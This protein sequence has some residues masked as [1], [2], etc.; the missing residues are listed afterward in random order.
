MHA[1]D[2]N[3]VEHRLPIK[4]CY[5]PVKQT[6]RRISI[7]TE[8]NVKENIK[9]LKDAGFVK[10]AKYT[11]WLSNI[12]HVLKKLNRAIKKLCGLQKYK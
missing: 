12:V 3:L 7:E 5:K 11:E 4:K 8:L 6:Q 1:L 2:R 9:S 10:T